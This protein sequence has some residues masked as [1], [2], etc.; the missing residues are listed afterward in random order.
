MRAGWAAGL[1]SGMAVAATV[2]GTFV[3]GVPGA[4]AGALAIGAAA[5]WVDLRTRRIPNRLVAASAVAACLG[6][7]AAI[8][9]GTPS[10]PLA[11]S[12]GALAFAGPLFVTHL[13]APSAIGFGDVKLALALGLA[14]GLVDPRLGI[15]ALCVASGVTAVVGIATGRRSLPLGPGLVVGAALAFVLGEAVRA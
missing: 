12:A 7:V 10:A 1:L 5:A 15:L 6:I 3:L 11:A 8:V 9:R 4:I 2:A 13:V 14:L